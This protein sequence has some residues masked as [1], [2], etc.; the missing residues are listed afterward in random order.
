MN[1][2]WKRGDTYKAGDHVFV[3]DVEYVCKVDH[4]AIKGDVSSGS[5]GGDLFDKGLWVAL[6]AK[7]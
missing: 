6:G 1:T 2:T 3:Y 7:K 5:F 4:T